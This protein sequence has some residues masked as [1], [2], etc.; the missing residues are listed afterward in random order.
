MVRFHFGFSLFT[1]SLTVF[2]FVSGFGFGF[3]FG[4]VFGFGFCHMLL[5]P[6]LP[7]WNFKNG[8][9][10]LS[11]LGINIHIMVFL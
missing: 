10:P 5:S 1:V 11:D 2:V 6:L 9:F 3:G 7:C 8:H 4:F